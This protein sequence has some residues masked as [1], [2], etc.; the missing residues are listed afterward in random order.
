MHSRQWL[1]VVPLGLWLALGRSSAL[2]QGNPSAPDTQLKQQEERPLLLKQ[3]EERPLLKQEEER[4]LLPPQEPERTPAVLTTEPTPPTA[5]LPTTAEE[6]ARLA[7]QGKLWNKFSL[8]T[9]RNNPFEDLYTNHLEVQ[10]EAKYVVNPMLQF[11][12]GLEANSFAHGNDSDWDHDGDVRLQNAYVNLALGKVNVRLGNQVVRWGK[13]DEVS[14]L[15]NLN[16]EDFRDGFVRLRTDRKLP[17]PM[18]NVEVSEGVYKWQGL[19]LPV[20]VR[21]RLPLKGSDW[22]LFN[23]TEDEI[24]PFR[25]RETT[26]PLTLG[27]GEVGTRFSGKLQA[28]DYAVSYLYTHEDLPAF[29]TLHTPP[30]FVVAPGTTLRDFGRFAQNTAQTIVLDHNRQHILGF[31]FETVLGSFGIRGDL[32][33]V[34]KRHVLTNTLQ[35]VSKPTVQY[36]IGADYNGLSD[37]YMNLQ[38]SQTFLLNYTSNILFANRLTNEFNGKIS[39]ELFN[40]NVKLEL[41]YFYNITDK[42]YYLNPLINFQHWQNVAIEVGLDLIDGPADTLVG[43]FR[44][45]TQGYVTL[46]V[47]F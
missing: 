18:L 41:R 45:N 13:A 21:S 35:A 22:A 47:A 3:E 2:A 40:K 8:D 12:L 38:F 6:P 7:L 11:V 27:N 20:F 19:F 17:I 5:A 23:H 42:T 36:I 39:Q 4:P 25:L 30:G 32:A 44:D 46:K 31:E 14:P 28:V 15:D 9:K 33:Y 16:P 24:G 26:P 10:A 1:V 37:F 43:L 29:R 34:S